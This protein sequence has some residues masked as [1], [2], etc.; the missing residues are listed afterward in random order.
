MTDLAVFAD[1]GRAFDHDAVLDDGAFADK[2]FI[3]DERAAFAGVAEF[4]LEVRGEVILDFLQGVPGVLATVENFRMLGLGQV[5][6]VGRFEHAGNLGET[7][8]AAMPFLRLAGDD[9]FLPRM[10]TDKHGYLKSFFG[11]RRRFF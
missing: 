5:K 10:D 4:G 11:N 9:W 1:D 7:M 8:A 6:Q 2:N 3:A